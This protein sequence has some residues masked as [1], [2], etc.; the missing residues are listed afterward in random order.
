[1]E[2]PRPLLIDLEAGR[3]ARRLRR[4][5]T[6]KVVGNVAVGLVS[7]AARGAVRPYRLRGRGVITFWDSPCD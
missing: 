5:I 6:I 2:H 3:W 1:M 4:P 7:Y